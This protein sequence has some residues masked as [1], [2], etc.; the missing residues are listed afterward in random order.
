MN[1]VV[2]DR[3]PSI[4][5][6]YT[7]GLSLRALNHVS[8]LLNGSNRPDIIN[9][10][11]FGSA[12]SHEIAFLCHL[13]NIPFIYSPHYN[14]NAH[15]LPAA[16]FILRT[17]NRLSGL[18][19]SWATEIVCI[20]EFEKTMLIRDFA[21]PESKVTVIPNGV[22][23]I[24]P[25]MR[26][27]IDVRHG[28]EVSLLYVGCIVKW[29]GIQHLLLVVK[30]LTRLG[31]N[32]RLSIAGSGNYETAL[33]REASSLGISDRLIWCGTVLG[34]MVNDLYRKADVFL[35]LSVGENYGTVVAEAL[36][37]GTPAI[38]TTTESALIEFTN[39]PGCYGV[40]YPPDK[41]EVS[42]IVLRILERGTKVGPF[43]SKIRTWEEIAEQYERLYERL[44]SKSFS[45]AARTASSLTKN[46]NA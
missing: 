25:R 45:R 7:Y 46:G 29:K 33:R 17:M 3:L 26:P 43:S 23:E 42:D 44:S 18:S 34:E 9:L 11:T 35:M 38:V 14:P 13:K 4:A 22:S 19:L 36:A 12:L 21:L 24:R 5:S 39:E 2:I 1:G 27:Q 15:T 10:H 37:Q 20:S 41:K 16:D 28:E 30:E 6:N 31:V 8:K 32:V 40:S